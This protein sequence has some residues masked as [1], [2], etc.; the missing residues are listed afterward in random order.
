MPSLHIPLFVFLEHKIL[1]SLL[2]KSLPFLQLLPIPEKVIS[3]Q[4]PVTF[5]VQ[6]GGE[7]PGGKTGLLGTVTQLIPLSSSLQGALSSRQMELTTVS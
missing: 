3:S 2:V 1:F 6:K 5:Q 7:T 4:I